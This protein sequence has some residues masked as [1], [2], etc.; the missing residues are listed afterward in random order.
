ML[1]RAV[2]AREA[3][4]MKQREIVNHEDESRKSDIEGWA[5]E[6]VKE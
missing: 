2:L 1:L 3:E 4:Q 5:V 6:E